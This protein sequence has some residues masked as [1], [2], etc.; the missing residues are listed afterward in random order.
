MLFKYKSIER[1]LN[2][3]LRLNQLIQ[4]ATNNLD[5]TTSLISGPAPE[6]I[7]KSLESEEFSKVV[8]ERLEKLKR[9]AADIIVLT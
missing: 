6:Q 8:S 7:N 2:D 5:N 4:K 3:K 1:R 9:N